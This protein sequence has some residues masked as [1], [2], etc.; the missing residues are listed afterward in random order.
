MK[1]M[2]VQIGNTDDKLT[3]VE[4]SKFVMEVDDLLL[5]DNYNNRLNRHFFGAATNYMPWQNACWVVATDDLTIKYITSMLTS[6]RK[7]YKQDSVAVT[8]GETI[9]V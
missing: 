7:K 6:I 1:T 3:Q 5:P 8:I 2:T 9:F 4:W